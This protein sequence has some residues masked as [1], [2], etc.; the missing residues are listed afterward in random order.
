ML[1]DAFITLWTQKAIRLSKSTGSAVPFRPV[2][3]RA[4]LEERRT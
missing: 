4:C 1:K 3:G 2:Q